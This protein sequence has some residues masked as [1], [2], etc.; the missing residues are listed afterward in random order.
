[1]AKKKSKKI[2]KKSL[3]YNRYYMTAFIIAAF[4]LTI[5]IGV[6]TTPFTTVQNTIP[7]ASI[8]A[9]I[10]LEINGETFRWAHT[11]PFPSELKEKGINGTITVKVEINEANVEI[12]SIKLSIE[13]PI[14]DEIAL[15]EILTDIWSTDYNTTIFPDGTYIFSLEGEI[16]TSPLYRTPEEAALKGEI[17]N[18]TYDKFNVIWKGDSGTPEEIFGIPYEYAVV[19]GIVIV[20]LLFTGKKKQSQAVVV[21]SPQ[22]Y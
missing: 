2:I 21:M 20:V 12:E 19:G 4:L 17:L 11:D 15:V 14:N 3:W 9:D 8:N 13:G 5:Y 7:D 10:V 6:R 1:M 16:N 22:Q 18:Y